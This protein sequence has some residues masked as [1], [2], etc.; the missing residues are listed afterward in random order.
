MTELWAVDELA[1]GPE[2]ALP[3]IEELTTGAQKRRMTEGI[4]QALESG[5]RLVGPGYISNI[6]SVEID[7]D[8]AFVDDCSLDRA[9]L[10]SSEGELITPEAD[11]FGVRTTVLVVVEGRWLVEDF[12]TSERECDPETQA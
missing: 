10:Y 11:T 1:N 8:R 9:E 2:A 5:E 6:V 4:E 3:L 7:G 12:W